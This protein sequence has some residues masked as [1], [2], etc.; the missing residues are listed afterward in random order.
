MRGN[1]VPTSDNANALFARNILKQVEANII[2]ESA[3]N[4]LHSI[5]LLEAY[6]GKMASAYDTAAISGDTC[7]FK[8][9]ELCYTITTAISG[10]KFKAIGHGESMPVFQFALNANLDGTA[11]GEHICSNRSSS[12]ADIEKFVDNMQHARPSFD[13]GKIKDAPTGGVTIAEHDDMTQLEKIFFIHGAAGDDGDNDSA[14]SSISLCLSVCDTK[15][16]LRMTDVLGAYM[17]NSIGFA[18]RQLSSKR[19]SSKPPSMLPSLYGSNV[20][21]STPAVLD[22]PPSNPL[23]RYIPNVDSVLT[24]DF[25]NSG[26]QQSVCGVDM[27]HYREFC[28]FIGQL[29][30]KN[31]YHLNEA[32]QRLINSS[33]FYDSRNHVPPGCRCDGWHLFC[34]RVFTSVGIRFDS[35]SASSGV[36]S[37]CP[38]TTELAASDSK[39]QL[40]INLVQ[41]SSELYNDDP[42]CYSDDGEV[43]LQLYLVQRYPVCTHCQSFEHP[44]HL[45]PVVSVDVADVTDGYDNV[46]FDGDEICINAVDQLSSGEDGI[47]LNDNALP[48]NSDMPSNAFVSIGNVVSSLND[49]TLAGEDTANVSN[50][51]ALAG[52]DTAAR[53]TVSVST[54]NVLNGIALAGED[55]AARST[56]SVS[57]DI[58]PAEQQNKDEFH[59]SGSQFD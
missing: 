34:T 56:V 38:I 15:N 6:A 37:I 18:A 43:L 10:T 30:A 9:S 25:I 55:T 16:N 12:A 46:S 24:S 31:Q 50:C 21:N 36:P 28:L 57:T 26:Q 32:M 2:V 35:A 19:A 47:S 22:I 40:H 52:E 17:A 54:A 20:K 58:V 5:G 13:H 48:E 29:P 59:S 53:L 4:E 39:L 49:L 27:D 42:S 44:T 11:H 51:I 23:K 33:Q 41:Q 1:T 3:F 45:C 8:F 14:V 7:V